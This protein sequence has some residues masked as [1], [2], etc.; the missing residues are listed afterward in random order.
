MCSEWK[1]LPDQPGSGEAATMSCLEM[2][3][4]FLSAVG[5]VG[6]AG[7]EPVGDARHAFFEVAGHRD[8]ERAGSRV[9]A[10]LERVGYTAGDEDERPSGRFD[11]LV[12]EHEVHGSF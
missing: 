4:R 1:N 6:I 12:V 9:A 2:N 11:P 7:D 8:V 3:M 10:V 5:G